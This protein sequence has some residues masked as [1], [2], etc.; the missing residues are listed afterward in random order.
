MNKLLALLAVFAPCAFAQ[1]P[2]IYATDVGVDCIVCVW[3]YSGGT[4][5]T[6]SPFVSATSKRYCPCTLSA[7]PTATFSVMVACRS[8]LGVTSPFYTSPVFNPAVPAT[9]TN[10][11]LVGS[12]A[13][14][15]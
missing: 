15:P 9:P 13:E 4:E 10:G 11:R 7:L 8:A 6:E 1:T 12:T 14:L 2:Q 5:R 3:K